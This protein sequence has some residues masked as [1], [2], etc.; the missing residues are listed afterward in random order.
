MKIFMIQNQFKITLSLCEPRN[1]LCWAWG[2]FTLRVLVIATFAKHFIVYRFWQFCQNFPKFFENHD[3][4]KYLH[5]IFLDNLSQVVHVEMLF[6]S[7]FPC[8]KGFSTGLMFVFQFWRFKPNHSFAC[9][10][11]VLNIKFND[12]FVKN[13]NLSTK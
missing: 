1:S 5:K 2:F 7:L 9:N 3:S 11:I 10:G 13:N 4:F 8:R 12:F 6:E